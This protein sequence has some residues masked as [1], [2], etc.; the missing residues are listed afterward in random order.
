MF[1]FRNTAI[2]VIVLLV[3]FLIFSACGRKG[4]L[5]TNIKPTINITSYEGVEE[6]ALIDSIQP[7]SFQQK[8]YWE[9]SDED[10]VVEKYAFRV[11]DKDMQPF[12][13]I[14]GNIPGL[15]TLNKI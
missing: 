4:S 15:I 9:A 6:P 11:V 3:L 12:Q 5:E 8:I 14:Q 1:K 13:N 10:G 2:I 7:A